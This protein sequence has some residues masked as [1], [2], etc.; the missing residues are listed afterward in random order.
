MKDRFVHQ[1]LNHRLAANVHNE[2]N[3]RADFGNVSKILLRPD[4]YIGPALRAELLQL[5]DNRQVGV[6]V[7][8]EVV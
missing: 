3:A 2:S 8:R 7:R 4:A 5:I 6:L 1:M